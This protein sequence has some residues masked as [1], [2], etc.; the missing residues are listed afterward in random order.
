M[1]PAIRSRFTWTPKGWNIGLGRFKYVGFPFSLGFG[2]GRL[3]YAIFQASTAH[4]SLEFGAFI[5]KRSN[6][7]APCALQVPCLRSPRSIPSAHGKSLMQ[8]ARPLLFGAPDRKRTAISECCFWLR[9]LV[10]NTRFM[11]P[12]VQPNSK[13]S[14]P[15]FVSA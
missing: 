5:N 9:A 15:R 14:L 2:V 13:L 6:H 12:I 3:L 11:K 8:K 1:D 10:Q 7:H 4:G